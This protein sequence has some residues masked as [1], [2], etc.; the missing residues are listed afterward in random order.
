MKQRRVFWLVW[1]VA[2][3]PVLIALTSYLTGVG[4]P[5]ARINKGTLIP[6]GSSLEQWQIEEPSGQRWAY[7]GRW[8]LLLIKPESC[9]AACAAWLNTMPGLHQALGRDQG[10]VRWHVVSPAGEEGDL[11]SER[12]PD[13]RD[14]IWV[15]DPNGNLVLYYPFLQAPQ[16][17]LRDLR[18]VLRASRIG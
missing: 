12:L 11:V 4:V 1:S 5:E 2:L 7:L 3:V 8:Q 15:A 6:P 17:L 18:K 10:R 9:D 14:G 16:D 13:T